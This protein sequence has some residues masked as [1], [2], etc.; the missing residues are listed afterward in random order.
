MIPQ[1]SSALS[2]GFTTKQVIDFLLKKFPQH[3]EKIKSAMA[4]GF[5][6]DQVI[7]FLSG[8][9]KEMS[10]ETSN[11]TEHEQTRGVYTKQREN[12]NKAG[13][14]VAG[15]GATALAAP[16]AAQALKRA[17]PQNLLGSIPQPSQ[18]A[19]ATSPEITASQTQQP[20]VSQPNIAQPQQPIQPEVKSI[21]VGGLLNKSG[22][23]KHVDDLSKRIKDPK[24]IAAVLYSKYPDEMKAFQK[25]SGK[26]MEDAIGDYLSSNPMQSS[27]N[28]VKLD[29]KLPKNE[30]ILQEQEKKPPKIEKSSIVASPN[31]IGTVKEV[32][33]GNALIDVDGKLHK[34]KE[35]EL[36][37]EP[38][39]V[40]NAKFDFDL[41]SIPEDL[42]SAP[43]NEVYLPHDRR[44][45][46][47]KY[48]V[49]LKPQR[50]IYFRK[51]GK[52]IPTD[53]INKGCLEC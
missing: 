51:D 43:L 18:Q 7:K 47:V 10:E 36:E 21:D 15:L 9:K 30:E 25:E 23:K 11:Q 24:Q 16:M 28:P 35:E 52:N 22:L 20:P 29:E 12:V 50:Y 38:E 42:R 3:S 48:N 37:S 6:T 1:I 41:N 19:Q 14:A 5:T 13:V 33:N 27:A 26:N 40:K 2:N 31:G 8:G 45:V 53:Y 44:H 17:I 34:V 39:E 46:T 4:A 49:G 32:R